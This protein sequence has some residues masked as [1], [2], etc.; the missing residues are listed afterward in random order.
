MK[1]TEVYAVLR[2]AWDPMLREAGFR[3]SAGPFGRAQEHQGHCLLIGPQLSHHGWDSINGSCFTIHLDVTATNAWFG[4]WSEHFGQ[5]LPAET[6]AEFVLR[7]QQ[8]V[9][10]IDD[11]AECAATGGGQP[12][13]RVDMCAA[14]GDDFRYSMA[15]TYYDEDDV[16]AW[17]PLIT[18]LLLREAYGLHDWRCDAGPSKQERGSARRPG[19]IEREDFWAS[20]RSCERRVSPRG[21]AQGGEGAVSRRYPLAGEPALPSHHGGSATRP[22]SSTAHVH[23]VGR[24]WHLPAGP[25]VGRRRSRRRAGTCPCDSRLTADL[26]K[27]S[28]RPRVGAAICTR[29]TREG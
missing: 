24:S 11:R 27:G 29:G 17:L 15:L 4:A 19:E 13:G 9:R 5:G 22:R 3:R 2:E 28:A 26:P 12:A 6:V 25:L 1:S 20:C 21:T 8:V 16:R 18:P 23:P 7:Q 10:R 14:T